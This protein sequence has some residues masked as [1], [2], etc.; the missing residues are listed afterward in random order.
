MAADQRGQRRHPP[1][2]MADPVGQG[3]TLDLDAFA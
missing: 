3:G 2:D 1:G